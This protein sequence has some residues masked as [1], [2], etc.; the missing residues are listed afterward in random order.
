MPFAIE[1]Y[2]DE[3]ADAAVRH[4]WQAIAAAGI[5]SPMLEAGYQ[6]HISLAVY[7][8]DAL[9][10]AG[11]KQTLNSFVA[12]LPP[13]FVDL[14]NIG[15]FPTNEGVIFLGATVTQKLQQV[16]AGFHAAFIEFARDLRPYYQVNHWVPHCTLAYGFS[17]DEIAT[18]LPL[19]WQTP[20]PLHAQMCQIGIAQVSP[21]SCEFIS[22]L[23]LKKK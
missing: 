15:L 8:N 10:L 22:Q 14:A 2:F 19:C 7:D 12:T 11:L 6:P 5:R 20:L 13:F 21:V 4:I 23:Q 9:D 3:A 16:H 17:C 1:L 18:I